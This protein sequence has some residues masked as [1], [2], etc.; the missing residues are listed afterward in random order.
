VILQYKGERYS[1]PGETAT[2]KDLFSVTE[3][4][5][6]SGWTVTKYDSFY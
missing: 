4:K 2:Y 5:K 6:D 1:S 3:E